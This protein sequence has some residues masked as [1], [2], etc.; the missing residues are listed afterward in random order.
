MPPDE[1]FGPY[2]KDRGEEVAEVL[3]EGR[4]QP[5][6]EGPKARTLDLPSQHDDLPKVD[7]V[8]PDGSW[9]LKARPLTGGLDAK[10]G[11]WRGKG[12]VPIGGRFC[13]GI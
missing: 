11:G 8:D 1:G 3:H 6:I 10:P 5:T 7:G 12:R 13:G 4:E 9:R 2:H